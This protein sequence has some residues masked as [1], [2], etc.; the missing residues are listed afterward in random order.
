[1]ARGK[2]GFVRGRDRGAMGRKYRLCRRKELT[3]IGTIHEV[4]HCRG[5]K[6][7]KYPLLRRVLDF[8]VPTLGSHD[9]T[10]D[11]T[12]LESVA[13]REAMRSGG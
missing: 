2:C 12:C 6:R 11:R 5:P 13:M 1:M 8:S 10:S 9:T 3:A 7:V 4:D